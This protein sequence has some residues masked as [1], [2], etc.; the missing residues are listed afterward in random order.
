ME[1]VSVADFRESLGDYLDRTL[2]RGESFVVT[3]SGSPFALLGP[4]GPPEQ[5]PVIQITARDIRKELSRIL[6]KVHYQNSKALILRRGKPVA[7]LTAIQTT[8][9]Q[10]SADVDGQ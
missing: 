8:E 9:N 5:A 1:Q 6:G 2:Y 3:R 7:M 10:D 4:A